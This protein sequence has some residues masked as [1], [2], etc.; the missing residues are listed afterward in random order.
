[1]RS[2]A[3]IQINIQIMRTFTKVR[4][5]MSMH[6]DVFKRMNK[7]ELKQLDQSKEIRRINQVI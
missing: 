7:L 2:K 4:E 6:K 1:L 3:A 5:L